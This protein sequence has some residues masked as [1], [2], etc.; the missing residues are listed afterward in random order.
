[1]DLKDLFGPGNTVGEEERTS[2]ILITNSNWN[3]SQVDMKSGTERT[4]EDDSQ[5]EMPLLERLAEVQIFPD[6]CNPPFL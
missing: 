4:W 1:M 3:T 5:I 2:F 6:R